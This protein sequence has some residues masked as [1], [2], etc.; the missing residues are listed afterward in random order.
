MTKKKRNIKK[1]VLFVSLSIVFVVACIGGAMW[2]VST[3]GAVGKFV[4]HVLH[5][6]GNK[7]GGIA[8]ASI[9]AAVTSVTQYR[10]FERANKLIEDIE[11]NSNAIKEMTG[12]CS[13]YDN[14]PGNNWQD[15]KTFAQ[16]I[17]NHMKDFTEEIRAPLEYIYKRL[18][19]YKKETNKII[20]ECRKALVKY[21]Q[22]VQEYQ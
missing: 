6:V 7:I 15:L 5:P 19:D 13:A 1:A 16:S 18:E 11:F 12:V 3:G 14:T 22:Y 8:A 2:I 10:V 9:P 17:E 4:K 20:K 21:Q